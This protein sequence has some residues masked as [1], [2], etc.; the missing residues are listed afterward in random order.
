MQSNTKHKQSCS[1]SSTRHIK[2]PTSCEWQND[3]KNTCTYKYKFKLKR[4]GWFGLVFF[5][6]LSW[7]DIKSGKYF[8]S[9]VKPRHELTTLPNFWCCKPSM[10]AIS[11][12]FCAANILERLKT[13][14]L[15]SFSIAR[16]R[17]R[18]KL[19]SPASY[20]LTIDVSKRRERQQYIYCFHLFENW[21]CADIL[22]RVNNGIENRSIRM[23]MMIHKSLLWL[24]LLALA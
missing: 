6:L 12:G 10:C 3:L 5:L 4:P 20:H 13:L 8:G 14:H 7:N 1:S 11:M 19:F 22:L 24:P 16:Y 21:H 9:F 15:F 2:C 17:R 18:V 23:M